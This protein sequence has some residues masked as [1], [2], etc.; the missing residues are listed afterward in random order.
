[1]TFNACY[2]TFTLPSDANR[3][4]NKDRLKQ[5]QTK[6]LSKVNDTTAFFIQ[7]SSEFFVSIKVRHN[8]QFFRF[9]NGSTVRFKNFRVEKFR[10]LRKKVLKTFVIF[11]IDHHKSF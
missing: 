8:T 6:A 2:L 4:T 7:L 1:M 11:E 10:F 3:G 9:Y 5:T